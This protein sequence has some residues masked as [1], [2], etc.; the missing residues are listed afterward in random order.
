MKK[1][2]LF[3]GTSEGRELACKLSLLP[4]ALTV[5]VATDYGAEL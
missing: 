4:L 5:S 3:G 1:V 2:I